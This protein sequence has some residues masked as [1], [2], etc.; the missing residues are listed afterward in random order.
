MSACNNEHKEDKSPSN[1]AGAD[2]D[3][4]A[5][6]APP[7]VVNDTIPATS[8]QWLDSTFKDVGMVKFKDSALVSFRFRNTGDKPLIVKS[9]NTTCGCTVA[10]TLHKPVM[11]G[12]ESKI[13][14]K[15]YSATQAAAIHEKHVYV[16]TNTLPYPGT[17]LTFKVEVKN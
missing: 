10:D 11:P 12:K 16:I 1:I 6:K 14:V 15:F 13:Q 17:T 3:T 9:V 4:T 8:I 7:P 2:V 5:V